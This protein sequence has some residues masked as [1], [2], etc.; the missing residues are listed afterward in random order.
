MR[1]AVRWCPH[2]E[3]RILTLSV[4]AQQGTAALQ[5]ANRSYYLAV[6]W[7]AWAAAA[8]LFCALV[9]LNMQPVIILPKVHSLTCICKAP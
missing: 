5:R 9:T 7:A 3:M 2:E 6:G 8:Q 4:T 1:A